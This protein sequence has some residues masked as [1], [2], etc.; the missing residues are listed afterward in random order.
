MENIKHEIKNISHLY[1]SNI[2]VQIIASIYTLNSL[3]LLHV[4]GKLKSCVCERSYEKYSS[5]PICKTHDFTYAIC[6]GLKTSENYQ[7]QG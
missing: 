1:F 5:M 7:R 4:L 2:D 3:R 6:Q